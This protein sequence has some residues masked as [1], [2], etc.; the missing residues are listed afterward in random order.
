[1]AD[2]YVTL[3]DSI[4]KGDNKALGHGREGYYFG[5]NGE[6]LMYDVSKA[7]ASALVK[8]GKG[9]SEEPTTFSKEDIDKY[10]GGV[11]YHIFSIYGSVAHPSISRLIWA[12]TLAV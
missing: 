1:V 5:A 6:H 11:G 2:L 3:Y 12:Q 4:L 10:F 9:K 8:L 7:V